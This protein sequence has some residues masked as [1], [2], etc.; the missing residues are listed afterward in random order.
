MFRYFQKVNFIYTYEQH[1]LDTM[2]AV[3]NNHLRNI[4]KISSKIIN[5]EH[6]YFSSNHSLL[7]LTYSKLVT[8]ISENLVYS[9][10][11]RQGW[12]DSN[13]TLAKLFQG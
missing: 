3:Y 7:T 6:M 12:V 8:L 11:E 10:R 1:S 4:E 13:I 9:S 2:N 5:V